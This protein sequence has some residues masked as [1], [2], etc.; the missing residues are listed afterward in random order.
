VRIHGSRTSPRC[1]G[2]I[3]HH[4]PVECTSFFHKQIR[5]SG[6]HALYLF[7]AG[8]EDFF[9]AIG[10]PVSSRTASAPQPTEEEMAER[11]IRVR[12]LAANIRMERV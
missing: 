11:W 12:P 8:L 9:L 4:S 10:L 7:T 3:D 1:P 5:Q 6:A 2:R